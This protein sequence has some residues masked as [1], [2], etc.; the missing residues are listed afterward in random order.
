MRKPGEHPVASFSR[1]LTDPAAPPLLIGIVSLGLLPFIPVLPGV[2]SLL[3]LAQGV[4][5]WK[6]AGRP[7]WPAVVA[8]A[9][10]ALGSFL[11]AVQVATVLLS[12]VGVSP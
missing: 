10:G 12:A 1:R 11:A 7:R 8:I 9:I 6:G 5:S 3:V 2:G 4:L